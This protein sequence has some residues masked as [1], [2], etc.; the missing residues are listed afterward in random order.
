MIDGQR[1]GVRKGTWACDGHVAAS[2]VLDQ[3]A[4]DE[5]MGANTFG[6]SQYF[7]VRESPNLVPE[8]DATQVGAVSLAALAALARRLRGT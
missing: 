8:P 4:F 1:P 7:A 2:F 3:A 6:L 5:R